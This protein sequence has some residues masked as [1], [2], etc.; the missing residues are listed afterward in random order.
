M[1]LENILLNYGLNEKQA[2]IY[3]A[4]LELGSASVQRISQKADMARS[5]CYEVLESLQKQGLVST[6]RKK[7]VKYF[8]AEDPQ[9]AVTIMKQKTDI[10]EAALPQLR[11]L[12]GDSRVRPTVRFYQGD[13]QMKIIME[14][15]LNEAKIARG[16]GSASGLLLVMNDYWPTF[17]ERRAKK[18]IPARAILWESKIAHER[19]KSGP[20]VLREVRIIPAKYKNDGLIFLWA[21]KIG[22]FSFKKDLTALVIESEELSH[23]QK[24]MF[25]FIWDHCN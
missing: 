19:K 22:M 6:F 10:L 17:V 20:S 3:L 1:K 21:N 8:S 9:K 16:F 24:T 13:Q 7:S 15:V 5:T 18:R 2:K 14:E 23:V 25:D 11:A 12:H 4:C